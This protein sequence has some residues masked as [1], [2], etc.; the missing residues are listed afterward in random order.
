MAALGGKLTVAG[1]VGT[2][3]VDTLVQLDSYTGTLLDG[4]VDTTKTESLGGGVTYYLVN[5][6]GGTMENV[7]GSQVV[8]EVQLAQDKVIYGVVPEPRLRFHRSSRPCC[9]T[10]RGRCSLRARQRP[11][12]RRPASTK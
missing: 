9:R 8:V 4:T 1:D 10:L 3:P 6:D 11:R 7:F 12:N 5:L 2:F